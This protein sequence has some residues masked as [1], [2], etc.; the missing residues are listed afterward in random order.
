MV[1]IAKV[2]YACAL[3]VAIPLWALI[4][5]GVL[6]RDV[7]RGPHPDSLDAEWRK[8]CSRCEK[9][10]YWYASTVPICTA[11]QTPAERDAWVQAMERARRLQAYEESR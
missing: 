11:C 7:L 9:V 6:I 10:I 1:T 5:C 4:A 3:V 8:R 2:A